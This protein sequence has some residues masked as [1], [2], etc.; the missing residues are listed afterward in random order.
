MA[1]LLDSF[2]L[3]NASALILD[4][5]RSCFHRFISRPKPP[6][7][8]RRTKAAATMHHEHQAIVDTTWLH[9]SVSLGVGSFGPNGVV[10]F[11]PTRSVCTTT[12]V[13]STECDS[14]CTAD[15]KPKLMTTLSSKKNKLVR[16]ISKPSS[17]RDIIPSPAQLS[18][19]LSAR[20]PKPVSFQRRNICF[21]RV[22]DLDLTADSQSGEHEEVV[23]NFHHASSLPPPGVDLDLS[24]MWVAIDNGN[25]SHAPIAP[26]AVDAL[27]R[28][29]K[30]TAMDQSMWTADRKTERLLA[31]KESWLSAVWQKEGCVAIPPKGSADENEVMVWSGEFKHKL[32]GSE[33]PAVR[34]AGVVNMSAE[35]LTSLLLDS[36]RVK[37]YN[38]MS[39]G[40][41]E[42]IVLS[43]SFTEDGPFGKS[44]TKVLRS[45]SKPPL[46]RKIL[47]FVTI[48]HAKE[49]EDG[50]GYLVVSR[51]VTTQE[52]Q[53]VGLADSNILRSEILIGVNV[54]RK[55]D[56]DSDR[57]LM[58]NV[59][60]IRSPMIPMYIAKKIGLSAAA[61]F[62]TD[63]RK[64]C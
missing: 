45:E 11:N 17:I 2:I 43:D 32:Y 29:G 19:E 63:L 13:S 22:A 21:L 53:G 38:A 48:M 62:F 44:V 51:A 59:N 56:G 50:S 4:L 27:A 58:I 25:G 31:T 5:L 52:D 30:Q 8:F 49:L 7:R 16:I 20:I 24:E 6:M 26:F 41:E 39:L 40:R 37:E 34:A 15:K 18:K 54:I 23:P 47:Q 60:H 14:L 36:G 28:F 9:P 1:I 61:N 57:C 55:T 3:K 42:L 46:L 64:L 12:S 35:S 10:E 33:L